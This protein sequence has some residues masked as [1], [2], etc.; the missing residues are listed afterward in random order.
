MQ[1]DPGVRR[2][3]AHAD[4]HI[5][6]DD[7]RRVL[8]DGGIFSGYK[9]VHAAALA[10][11]GAVT[12]LSVYAIPGV[13]SPSPQALRAV[14][15][16]DSGG[17]PGALV[18]SGPEVTYRGTTNGSGWFDLPL[19]APVAL[20][21]GSYWLGFTTGTTSEGMGYRFDS[22]ANS[23]AYNTNA[24]AGGPTDPFG[25][26]TKDSEQASIYA[27]YTPSAPAAAAAA[28]QHVASERRRN[29]PG[30]PD[31]DCQPRRVDGK[32]QRLRLPV[33]AL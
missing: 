27:T 33:A 1:G 29:R 8:T 21:P 6:Q 9:V 22:A 11:A 31:A 14:I 10:T 13:N 15:Y 17:S 28:R 4:R 26:A 3:P 23:R 20:A 19:T 32:P 30:R 7:R 24:F 5:R 12:K 16:R 2:A 25:S 18:A